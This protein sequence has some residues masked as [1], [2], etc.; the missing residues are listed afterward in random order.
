MRF[1]NKGK[2]SPRFIRPFEILDRIGRLA[3]R[4]ALPSALSGVHDVFHVSQLRGYVLDPS[5][6]IEYG[7]IQLEPDLSFSETPIQIV[8]RQIRVLRSK[9]IPLVSVLWKFQDCIEPNCAVLTCIGP[10]CIVPA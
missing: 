1:R 7:Q 4:L 8:D 6:I 5:H 10:Y 2:L 9:T 3:Y